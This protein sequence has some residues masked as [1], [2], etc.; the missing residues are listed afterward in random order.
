MRVFLTGGTGLIGSHIAALLRHDGHEVVALRR[1]AEALLD[2]PVMPSPDR[3]RPIP[4]P[5]F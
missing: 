3:R 5:A 2:N 4:W 1:R